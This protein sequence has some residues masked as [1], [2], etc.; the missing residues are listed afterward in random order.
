MAVKVMAVP[1]GRA[2]PSPSPFMPGPC[3]RPNGAKVR[4]L[5]VV[6]MVEALEAPSKAQVRLEGSNA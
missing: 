6:P 4:V 3:G 2:F 1:G 5:A